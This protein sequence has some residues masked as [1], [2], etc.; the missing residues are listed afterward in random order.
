MYI[1]K[2]RKGKNPKAKMIAP[3]ISKMSAP[4]QCINLNKPDKPAI[5]AAIVPKIIFNLSEIGSATANLYC[6][7]ANQGINNSKKVRKPVINNSLPPGNCSNLKVNPAV[8]DKEP[9]KPMM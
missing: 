3:S 5:T 7:I 6:S 2:N 8:K 9:R 1:V 4:G